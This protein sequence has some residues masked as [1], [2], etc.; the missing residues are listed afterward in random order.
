MGNLEV[1][2][3]FRRFFRMTDSCRF[4]CVFL[5]SDT[6][7][8]KPSVHV[9]AHGRTRWTNGGGMMYPYGLITTT[10]HV[11]I[12]RFMGPTW[13]PPGSCRPQMG[14]MLAPWTLLSGVQHKRVHILWDVVYALHCHVLHTVYELHR[15][16]Q[17]IPIDFSLHS[18]GWNICIVMLPG[19][20]CT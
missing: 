1:V 9:L 16:A 7:S 14:P 18:R 15:G 5:I 20:G 12:A 2:G 11:Q 8:R 4:Y 10:K 17:I 3:Y 6:A 19:Y 13:G